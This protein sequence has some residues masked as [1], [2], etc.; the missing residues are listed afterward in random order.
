MALKIVTASAG[1]GKTFRLT[2]EYLI[3]CFKHGPNYFSRILGMTF[4][5]KAAWEMKESILQELDLLAHQPE[6]SKHK[7]RLIEALP[8]YKGREDKLREKAAAIQREVLLKYH[9]FSLTTIDSFFQ[10]IVRA[11]FRELNL[12]SNF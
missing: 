9:D 10:R 8:R 5:N 12:A 4:T 6:K 3:L 1:S 2:Q 7:E 11:F